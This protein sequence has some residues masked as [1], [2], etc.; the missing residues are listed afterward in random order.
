MGTRSIAFIRNIQAKTVSASGATMSFLPENEPRT[1][2]ST[3][4]TTH[5]TKFCRPSG[6]PAVARFAALLKK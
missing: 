3:N 1:F 4:S 5:S 6:I 2:W